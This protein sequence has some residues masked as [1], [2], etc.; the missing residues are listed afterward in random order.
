MS[1]F[2]TR[3]EI[4]SSYANSEKSRRKVNTVTDAMAKKGAI[5]MIL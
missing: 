3:L 4:G 5:V 2:Y 1:N